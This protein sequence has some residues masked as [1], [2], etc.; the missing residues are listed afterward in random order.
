M[1]RVKIAELMKGSRWP[2]RQHGLLHRIPPA[3]L[4]PSRHA[5]QPPS[6]VPSLPLFSV[7]LFRLCLHQLGCSMELVSFFISCRGSSQ[8]SYSNGGGRAPVKRALCL[9]LPLGQRRHRN[10][11]GKSESKRMGGRNTNRF[12]LQCETSRSHKERWLDCREVYA[13]LP[14]EYS[15]SLVHAAENV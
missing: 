10:E 1:K 3:P 9:L 11:S 12:H 14:E 15:T 7:D 6:F 8:S 2:L 5:S 13:S 4:A